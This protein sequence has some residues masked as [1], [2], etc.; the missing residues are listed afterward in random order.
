MSVEKAQIPLGYKQTEV[1]VIPEDWD[2]VQLE[3]YVDIKSGESP[4]KYRFINES[5]PYFKVE[6][7][8]NGQKLHHTK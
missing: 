5:I 1:G 6:Q 2:D 7:L 3:D 4:S 8:N